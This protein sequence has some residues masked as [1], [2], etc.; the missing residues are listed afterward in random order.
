M[1]KYLIK[2]TENKGTT[3]QTIIVNGKDYTEAYVNAMC[4][5]AEGAE[6]TDLFEI[7]ED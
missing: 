6:I 7:M 1:K 4:Q 3:Y 5:I 2:Y